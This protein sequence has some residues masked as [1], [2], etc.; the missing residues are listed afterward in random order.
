MDSEE[1]LQSLEQREATARRR[2]SAFGKTLGGFSREK[3]ARERKRE[4][5]A[6]GSTAASPVADWA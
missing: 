6:K 5:A 2:L 3:A 1:V 4:R